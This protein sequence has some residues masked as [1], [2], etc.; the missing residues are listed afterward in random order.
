[1]PVAEAPSFRVISIGLVA[2][3]LAT[4]AAPARAD[5]G[6]ASFYLLGSGGPGA[7]ELPPLTGIYFDSTTYFYDGS[8]STSRDFVIGGNVVAGIDAEILANFPTIL[9]VPTTNALGGTLALGV[10]LPVANPNI[11]AS[12]VL[13]GPGGGAIDVDRF[14]SATVV[15]DP[16][17]T[18]AMAW[19][20]ADDAHV[21]LTSMVNVP[22]GTYRE[23]ELANI[24][25]HRWIVDVSAAATWKPTGW[26][27]SGKVGITFNGRNDL[28]D[29]NSGNEVH[30]EGSVERKLTQQFSAGLQAYHLQQI[31]GDSGEGAKL[32]SFKGRVTGVGPTIAATVLL[33]KTPVTARLRYFEEFGVRNRLDGRAVF[34]SITAPLKMNLPATAFSA[35]EEK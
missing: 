17:L 33:G 27:V 11:E 15:G 32:G 18:A 9:W 22:I 3:L 29:Y 23:G 14:D 21:S 24:S 13:T 5:E 28:T 4:I 16:A 25:F 8:A 20:V 7:G 34:F 10:T 6:G 31:S 30:I 19:K 26:D 2:A 35:Q 1:M 12:A